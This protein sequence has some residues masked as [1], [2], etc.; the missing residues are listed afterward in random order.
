MLVSV[1]IPTRNRRVLIE[2]AVRSVLAQDHADLELFV[3]ND[4][5]TDDTQAFLTE[6]ARTDPRLIVFENEEPKGAPVARN[7]AISAA[8]GQFITGL[9][10]DDYFEPSRLRR[11][12]QRWAELEAEGK[13]PSCLY[14]QSICM[15]DGR[16]MWVSQK[17]STVDYEDLF[18][19]N[20][21][22]NQVFAPREHFIGAGMFDEQ[23]P[24]WQDIDLFIRMLRK[25]GT[26]FLAPYPTYFYDDDERTDRISAKG[27]RI[28]RAKV[29][30]AAKHQDLDPRLLL[31]LH[32]QM[33]S[34]FYDIPP[35]LAD[36]RM[37][38]ANK[39]SFK[40]WKRLARRMIG[41]QLGR[42][43]FS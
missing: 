12:L 1:Y 5:S 25:Y 2:R 9:D 43:R 33:F 34:G 19:R 42:R 24:A 35:T 10:D 17:P 11:F 37:L 41:R 36:V 27:E 15:R 4:A 26:A 28:R 40:H 6:L 21:I 8:K 29:R 22:E 18:T 13:R 38:L 31:A 16:Q 39:P 7:R 30:I 23:L 20:V 3:V 14:S 32:M